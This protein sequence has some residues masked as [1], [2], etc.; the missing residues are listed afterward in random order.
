MKM[1]SRQIDLISKKANCTC[2]TLFLLISKNQICT[3]THARFFVFPLPLFLHDYNAVCTTK[4]SN[5]LVTHFYGGIVVCAY[6]CKVLFP[7]F[8]LAFIF[9]CRWFSPYWPLT[10]LIFSPPLWISTFFFLR[11]LSPLFSVTLSSSFSVVNVSVNIKKLTPKK[12]R[13]CCC[14]VFLKVREAMWFP[15][16]YNLELQLGCHTC[17][18]SYFTLVYLWCGR[19]VARSLARCTVCTVALCNNRRTL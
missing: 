10:F 5:F 11:N 9:H 6:P 4:T 12:T 2:S 3:S 8:M 7:V 1:A 15:S 14:F 17:W 19:T 16:R 13:L 18:F